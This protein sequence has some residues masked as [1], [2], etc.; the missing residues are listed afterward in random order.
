MK[1]QRRGE[2]RGFHMRLNKARLEGDQSRA[3]TRRRSEDVNKV[4]RLEFSP[5]QLLA[6]DEKN[7][8]TSG[9]RED[10]F[11]MR[12]SSPAFKK[13]K[14]TVFFLHLWFCKCL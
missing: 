3:E 9:Q 13:K 10:N 14:V 4:H 7:V 5:S 2:T 1:T 6:L 11:R 8:S 12:K